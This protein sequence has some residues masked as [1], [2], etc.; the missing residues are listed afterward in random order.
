MIPRLILVFDFLE[1]GLPTFAYDKSDYYVRVKWSY[2]RY[3]TSY[4]HTHHL[5]I[6]SLPIQP[7]YLQFIQVYDIM[8]IFFTYRLRKKVACLNLLRPFTT[9]SCLQTHLQLLKVNLSTKS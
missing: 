7:L 3:N 6:T 9:Y 1:L 8:N 4:R 5:F 2:T